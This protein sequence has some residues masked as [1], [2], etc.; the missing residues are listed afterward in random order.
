MEW[1]LWVLAV[2]GFLYLEAL[3]YFLG[4]RNGARATVEATHAPRKVN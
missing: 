1:L 4:K 3:I 2:I